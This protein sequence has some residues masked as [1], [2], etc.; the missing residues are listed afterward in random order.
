MFKYALFSYIPR[1]FWHLAS[2]EQRDVCRIILGFKH[3]RNI[4]TRWAVREVSRALALASL[5]DVVI[6]CTPASTH[7][8]HVRRW[9]RFSRMLCKHAGAIDGFDRV[10]VVGRRKRAHV[11]GEY[12]LTN[13]IKQFVHVDTEYFRGKKS[14]SSTTYILP[15]SRRRLS[16]EKWKMPELLSSEL[17]SWQKR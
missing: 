2:F 11:T 9:K 14:W 4:Y 6:V 5:K 1:R 15:D 12:E 16:S 17:C 8:A 10:Q 7:Y 3:G 13:N